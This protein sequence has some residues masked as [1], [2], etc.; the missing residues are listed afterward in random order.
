MRSSV[1]G[2]GGETSKKKAM[3]L[4][5]KVM[6]FIPSER[7]GHSACYYQ[8]NVYVFGGCCGGLHFSDVLVL[9]LDTM[10]WT[11]MVTTG[12]SPGPRDSH[13]AV[14]VGNQM[15]V[16]GGTNGS[17][18]VN[19][20]HIL[21][22]G[23]KEWTQPECKGNPP[24]PRESHTAT[25]IGDDKLAIFGG[26]G[27][28]ESNY[29]N[30]L[31]ILN[32][33]TM[34]WMN[35]EVRGDVPIPRDS[36]SATAVGHKLL[37]YG[38][39]CGD[40]YQ[41][42]VDMLDMHSLTWSRLCV[43]GSSPGVRAG[44][45]A[46]N[47]ATKVYILGGVGDRQYYNDAW[48]LDLCTCSWTQ[49]ET[50]GQQPQGRFSHTAVVADSDIVIYGGCGEDERPLNDLLVLQ[51]GAAHPNGRYNVSMCKI[52][53]NHWNNQSKNSFRE[54]QSG[55]K[56]KL[57]GNNIDLIRKGDHEPKSETKHA[58]QFMSETLH[59]KRRRTMN[60]KVWEVESEQEEHSLSLSQHSSPSQ[61]DQ[62]QTPAR[63]VS[64]SVT[65]S[66]GGGLRLLKRVNHSS[67]SEPYSISRTQ[68]E[69]Q[70]VVQS[71]PQQ[72]LSYFRH[73]HQL[74]TEQQQL[75]HVERHKSLETG[76]IQNPIGSEV[77]GRVDGAF[78]SGFL[79]TATVNG[80]VYRG[81][82]FAPGPGVFSRAA[83]IVTESPPLPTNTVLNSNHI[84]PSKNLQQRPM[85]LM[86]ESAQ[87]LRQPQPGPP[88]VPI[89]K[90]SPSSLPVKL[91]DDLQGVFLT[92]GGP[93]NGSV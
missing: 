34:V 41:G 75:L 24:A 5:P 7:W 17:K 35:T 68:P 76:L 84:E 73:Q 64:D 42:G 61:S 44:H 50:C 22:L 45:A 85:V 11:N 58:A 37:V 65:S 25:L 51:L 20:L 49:L 28:G 8:G 6:G 46:V 90:P 32:L 33:K 16:F 69:F 53:G 30:D 80:K 36:H 27:E 72:E 26:S 1:G 29:L 12:H 55:M 67:T 43:Q 10:L 40:R 93:G 48:V 14:I 31:H 18:K 66:Q 78:D 4:Y 13:G 82:L 19:D 15:I 9:N 88:P 21:D 56:T 63:K 3:W 2:G 89:I 83:S 71:T 57:M 59:P 87:S 54:D 38:G 52:F 81:V 39:D 60:P 74:K 70:N 77:R 62:E 23:T 91:R 86:S 92:L 79:M 47:I